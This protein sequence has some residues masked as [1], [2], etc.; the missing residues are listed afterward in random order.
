MARL[1]IGSL[2]LIAILVQTSIGSDLRV[3]EVAPDFMVLLSICAGLVGGTEAGAWVGFWAGLVA[4]MFLTSTPVGLSALTYCL[5]GAATG[6]LRA[7]VLEE[8]RVLIPVLAFAGTV[9]GVLAF[10]AVGEV[11][12]QSQLLGAGRSWL[13]RVMFV[14]G[15]WSAILALPFIYVYSRAAR[16]SVGEERLGVPRSGSKDQ[17]VVV[18]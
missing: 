18:R 12:G 4:D 17:A 13:L 14:E 6:A 7:G 8:Q 11:L 9:V 15:M 1:R 16:G 10:V 5:I 2:L 3:W